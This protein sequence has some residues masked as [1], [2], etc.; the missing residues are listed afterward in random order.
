MAQLFNSMVRGFGFTLGRKAADAVTSSNKRQSVKSVSFSKK[1]LELIKTYEGIIEELT[2][3]FDTIES[4]YKNGTI[5]KAEY[6]NLLFRLKDQL[7]ETELELE[8]V[9]SIKPSNPIVGKVILGIVAIYS[10]IW[11]IKLIS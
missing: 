11:F 6:N 3:V 5:T 7:A 4:N 2:D 8:K 9:K 10:V 1:Q